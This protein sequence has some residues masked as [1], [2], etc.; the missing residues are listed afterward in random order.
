[1]EAMVPEYPARLTALSSLNLQQPK[2]NG[3]AYDIH[4][5]NYLL[6]YVDHKELPAGHSSALLESHSAGLWS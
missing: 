3:F 6:F 2:Q 5:E 4:I 1:M